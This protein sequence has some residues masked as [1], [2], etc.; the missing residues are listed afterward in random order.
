MQGNADSVTPPMSLHC[1][2][3]VGMATESSGGVER[4]WAGGGILGVRPVEACLT[5]AASYGF[6]SVDGHCHGLGD[7]EGINFRC[8]GT[9]AESAAMLVRRWRFAGL[10]IETPKKS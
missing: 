2:L 3:E 8:S 4:K 7:P 5:A 10:A 9:V 1:N 6:D